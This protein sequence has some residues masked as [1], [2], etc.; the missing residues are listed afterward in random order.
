MNKSNYL[1]D[2]F[3]SLL[4][5]KEKKKVIRTLSLAPYGCV[6][7]LEDIFSSLNQRYF[8][9]RLAIHV[10]WGRYYK[11]ASRSRRL[12]SYDH[13][14]NLIT[15]HPLLDSTDFP[16]YFISYIVYHE[17]LHAVYPPFKERGRWVIHHQ[18]FKIMERNFMEYELAKSWQSQNKAIF[19]K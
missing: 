13:R 5:K 12:G 6:Y 9:N 16:P 15:V 10:T 1:L 18:E 17:I 8:Q 14:K 2:I 7:N 11:Q 4:K 3:K 19:F